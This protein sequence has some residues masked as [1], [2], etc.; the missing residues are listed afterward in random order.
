MSVPFL[1]TNILL[2]HILNDDPHKSAACF[3]LI[4]AIER[5][6][7]TVWTSELA[8]AEV[9]F[10]LES[11]RTYNLPREAIRDVL[12]PLLGLSGIKLTH[13]RLY[14][15]IFD[16]YTHLPIDFIDCYHVALMEQRNNRDRTLFSYDTDFDIISDL[17]RREP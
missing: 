13:K 9:V 16:L 3:A 11:K 1:D 4:Q 6:D 2:R 10:V 12:L 17:T 7:T 15:R 5:G 14:P 8:I